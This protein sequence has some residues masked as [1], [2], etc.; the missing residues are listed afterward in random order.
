M[1]ARRSRRVCR[2]RAGACH[3]GASAVADALYSP[4]VARA[5]HGARGQ[6][7]RRPV[8]AVAAAAAVAAVAVVAAATLDSAGRS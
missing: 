6:P 7:R 1:Q 8:A 3:R 4:P 2:N 5:E